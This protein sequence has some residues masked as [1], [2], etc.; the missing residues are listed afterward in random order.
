MS[1]IFSFFQFNSNIF[2]KKKFNKIIFFLFS[3]IIFI[4]FFK[5]NLLFAY[6]QLVLIS[7]YTLIFWS[8]LG[9]IGVFWLYFFS[10]LI[11]LLTTLN[12]FF[13][14]LFTYSW[15]TDLF[16]LNFAIFG[17]YGNFSSL[18]S[19]TF[20]LLF[21]LYSLSYL[22]LTLSIGLWA[23]IFSLVYMQNE[24]RLQIFIS[25]LFFFLLSMAQLLIA[26]N[27]ETMFL[28]WEL[29]GFFS[30]LLINF[31][32]TRIIS[33]KSA[34]KAFTFNKI[35]DMS[36][37][38]VLVCSVFYLNTT[39]LNLILFNLS[40]NY[41]IN[42]SLTTSNINVLSFILIF[43]I[44]A[45]FC[46]SAQFGFHIWL[47]DSMEA[48]V[49]ASALIHS[50]TLVSAGIY[51]MGRFSGFLL[52]T[53]FFSIFYFWCAFTAF[54]GGFVAALQT[55]LKRLLAYSTISHCGFLFCSLITGNLWVTVLY[56]HF[57]GWFK[58]LSFMAAGY[59][60][61]TN[62][63]YQ[64]ARKFG[65]YQSI[66][67]ISFLTLSVAL[68][69]LGGIPFFIG[70]FNKFF[71]LTLLNYTHYFFLGHVFLILAT[72][73]GLFYS[74]QII[75]SVFM[76][77][78]KYLNSEKS[79]FFKTKLNLI[80]FVLLGYTVLISFVSIIVFFSIFTENYLNNWV[81]DINLTNHAFFNYLYPLFFIFIV[82][83]YFFKKKKTYSII[84]LTFIFLK[85]NY[86][87]L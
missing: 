22:S 4:F 39:D 66:N 65:S 26:G 79:I 75:L 12:T 25:L 10:L 50:A 73:C 53:D 60:I 48:P 2:F 31:W 15:D 82:F 47:P 76:G 85:L 55:D 23:L 13:L 87:F 19:P 84:L 8:Y 74:F 21:D 1:F 35:S 9:S 70:F 81:F 54:Y 43:L 59:L 77:N 29:I 37:L 62:H 80:N 83:I 6:W 38:L 3:T 58:S 5:L 68:L 46:K 78:K 71:V 18:W 67:T 44:I 45:S 41:N 42:Y 27:L 14:N 34:F 49:P 61:V 72:F 28:G 17:F 69:N 7:I 20:S 30:Y 40:L 36:L 57:H 11:M 51:L 64:D 32:N 16:S 24:P 56:L 63:G 52:F 33:F 86:V